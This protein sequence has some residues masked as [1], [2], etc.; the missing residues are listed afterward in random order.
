MK[1]ESSTCLD[2]QIVITKHK[3]FFT[4]I[5]ITSQFQRNPIHATLLLIP[6]G[7]KPGSFFKMRFLEGTPPQSGFLNQQCD[8]VIG[9]T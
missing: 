8:T 7:E 5:G 9:F 6:N 2:N 4:L 1:Q 3:A